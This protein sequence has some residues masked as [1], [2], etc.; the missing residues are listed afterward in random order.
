MASP[1]D[2]PDAL[3][4]VP[5]KNHRSLRVAIVTSIHP[6]FDSRLWKH[7]KSIKR[8]GHTV[9]M[10]CPWRVPDGEIRDGV[11]FRTF[12]PV[13]SR[14]QRWKSP[15]RIAK[16]LLPTLSDVDIV[17]FHD[18]DILPWMAVLSLFKNVVYDVHEN[19]PAEMLSREWV[20]R[21]L[22]RLLAFTVRWGQL[23]CANII[24]NVVLVAESQEADLFG[25][26]LNKIY[27]MNYAS[28]ELMTKASPDYS[29]R[30]AAVI[31]IGSQTINNGSLLYLEIA[32]SMHAQ[33]RGVIC[34]ASDRFSQNLPF[35]QKIL[36]Q[37]KAYGLEDVYRLLPN[38]LSHEL[39]SVLN[40][41]TVAISPN[42]RVKQQIDGVHT[43]IFEY[44]AAGL[45]VVASDLPHQIE[46][47]QGSDAGLLAQPEDP[48]SFVRAILR[49]LDDKEL[50]M[51]VGQNGQRAF[52]DRYSW[53][54]Q[55]SLIETYYQSIMGDAASQTAHL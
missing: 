5:Q 41:A 9:V 39:M 22:R 47:L 15:F 23:L 26:R 16:R 55:D 53:E 7:A 10:V 31:F 18:I 19:Y 54:S 36:D 44:L 28:M 46:V 51:R 3:P 2:R 11:L 52:L 43:K 25:A 12:P 8:L 14:S 29:S 48:E 40:Q 45:P 17:H 30:P 4:K 49:L 34:Y 13:L 6:D 27:I 21:V 33:R 38:V 35:R 24:K 20:P 42:L 32:K 50:A 37:V 1:S